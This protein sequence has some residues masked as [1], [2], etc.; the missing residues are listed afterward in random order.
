MAAAYLLAGNGYPDVKKALETLLVDP[1]ILVRLTAAEVLFGDGA[2]SAEHATR[3]RYAEAIAAEAR[4]AELAQVIEKSGM[5]EQYAATRDMMALGRPACRALAGLAERES[6]LGL[7]AT[8]ALQEIRAK[9]P[10]APP[11]WTHGI[12]TKLDEVVVNA[13]LSSKSLS[14][15]VAELSRLSGIRIDL[16]ERLRDRPSLLGFK[17]TG[18]TL[19]RALTYLCRLHDARFLMKDGGVYVTEEENLWD[20]ATLLLLDVR[21]LVADGFSSDWD[22]ALRAAFAGDPYAWVCD[23]AM[24]GSVEYRDGFLVLMSPANGSDPDGRGHA[25]PIARHLDRIRRE[26]GLPPAGGTWPTPPSADDTG[27]EEAP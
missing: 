4:V 11:A 19:R 15:A 5:K 24:G 16:D 20:G 27:T 8:Y 14:G 10:T 22:G 21:D 2:R 25:A 9:G 17:I 3:Y 26:R 13:N 12:E 18:S 1:D 7:S 6:V 23:P